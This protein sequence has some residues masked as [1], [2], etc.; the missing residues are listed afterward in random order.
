MKETGVLD[1]L[2]E[3]ETCRIEKACNYTMLSSFKLSGV[4]VLTY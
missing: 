3:L 4:P 2:M 1:Y